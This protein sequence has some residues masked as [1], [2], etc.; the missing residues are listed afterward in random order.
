[1]TNKIIINNIDVT[2][3]PHKTL[4]DWKMLPKYERLISYH[5]NSSDDIIYD[6]CASFPNCAFKNWARMLK[7]NIYLRNV[8][9]DIK[10]CR[11]NELGL[12]NKEDKILRMIKEAL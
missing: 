3:C 12:E 7:R 5:K 1:M 4:I 10:E 2:K 11:I 8:L 6:K 9:L